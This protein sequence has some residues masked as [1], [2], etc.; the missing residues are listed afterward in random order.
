M[1]HPCRLC[2]SDLLPSPVIRLEGMPPAA[3]YYPR[4]EEFAGDRGIT[5]A[6]RQCSGCGL[7]QLDREPVG[8]FREV[9][10]AASLSEKARSSRLERMRRFVALFGL[11]GKSVLEV[12][13]GQGAML[14]V[15]EQSGLRATGIEAGAGSVSLGRAA[16]RNVVPGYVGEVEA[17]PGAPFDAFVSLNYLEHLPEPGGII[18]KIHSLTGPGAAG[19]VTVPNLEYLLATKCF[20][21]FVAD[22]LC[23]FTRATLTHAFESNGFDVVACETVNEDNDIEVLVQKRAPLDVARQYGEVEALIGDLRRIVAERRSR[24]EKVA[25]WG[26]GHRTLALL[27][28]GG[29]GEIAFVVDSAKFKQGLFTPV[30][31]LE[32]AAPERLKADRVDLVLVMVPGLYPRE[33]TE[34]LARMDVGA[35]V[36]VLRGNKVEF[37]PEF[38]RAR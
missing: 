11:G 13:C 30:L 9:I 23:Y 33:V 37:L 4:E 26:A 16:G 25:V 10:T 34:T 31:H 35:E 20:Y 21:E 22:H 2:G 1:A 15:L 17:L 3:Q 6:V 8:Y 7:V 5:L 32:I 19:Y 24:G 36:A 38:R 28:L 18:R 14:E 12:G 27:A 29:L